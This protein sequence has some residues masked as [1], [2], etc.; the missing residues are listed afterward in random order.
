MGGPF[1]AHPE[2]VRQSRFFAVTV[3]PAPA[4]API[5]I[6][7]SIIFLFYTSI[8]LVYF[9]Y[10]NS[11]AFKVSTTESVVVVVCMLEV[12]S[13]TSASDCSIPSTYSLYS[14]VVSAV[15]L[16]LSATVGMEILPG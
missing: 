16:T 1:I 2:Y 3:V 10:A 6:V 5:F 14:T 8:S 7:A 9:L 13:F 15:V 4:T 11:L 12:Y